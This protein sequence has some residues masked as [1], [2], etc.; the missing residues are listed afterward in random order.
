[1]RFLEEDYVN[2]HRPK[3]RVVLDEMEDARKTTSS[4][5]P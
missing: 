4:E 2:N 3:S 5:V 1:V